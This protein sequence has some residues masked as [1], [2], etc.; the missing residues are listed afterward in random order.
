LNS[1]CDVVLVFDV[2]AG[3]LRESFSELQRAAGVAV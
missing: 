1:C 2:L 3:H